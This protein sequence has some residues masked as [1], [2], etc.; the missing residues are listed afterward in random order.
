MEEKE[1]REF[2]L[3]HLLLVTGVCSLAFT[4][5]MKILDGTT[6]S[7][8]LFTGIVSLGLGTLGLLGRLFFKKWNAADTQLNQQ[9]NQLFQ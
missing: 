2:S 7:I 1:M 6:L 9:D 5:I 4:A 8:F 3:T